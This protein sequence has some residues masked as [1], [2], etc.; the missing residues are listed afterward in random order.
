MNEFQLLTSVCFIFVVSVSSKPKEPGAAVVA[1]GCSSAQPSVWQRVH[2]WGRRSRAEVRGSSPHVSISSSL[3]NWTPNSTVKSNTG[4]F[5]WGL[6]ERRQKVTAGRRQPTFIQGVFFFF[7]PRR[8]HDALR[9]LHRTMFI[10]WYTCGVV[11]LY[12]TLFL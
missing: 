8:C 12:S 6:I 7:F 3:M 9:F 2:C 11:V 5:S 4:L 1:P 10:F